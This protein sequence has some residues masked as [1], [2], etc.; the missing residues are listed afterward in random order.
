MNLPPT[1][2]FHISCV[3]YSFFADAS[4]K[5]FSDNDEETG[6]K[7]KMQIFTPTP[8]REGDLS[9][10]GRWASLLKSPTCLND[11]KAHSDL[12]CGSKMEVDMFLQEQILF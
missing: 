8:L 4:G 1:R 6:L 12:C 9:F 11:E 7:E 5:F 10:L 3:R 2:L